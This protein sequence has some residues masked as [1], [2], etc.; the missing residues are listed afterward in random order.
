LRIGEDGESYLTE[1]PGSDLCLSPSDDREYFSGA[2]LDYVMEENRRKHRSN[3]DLGNY[4]VN[5]GRFG[6]ATVSRNFSPHTVSVETIERMGGE[7]G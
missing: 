6:Q 4:R 5:A 2:V 3:L 7:N 1:R